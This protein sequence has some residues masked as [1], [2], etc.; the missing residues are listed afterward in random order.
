MSMSFTTLTFLVTSRGTSQDECDYIKS[1][2]SLYANIIFIFIIKQLNS[3]SDEKVKV[4][5]ETERFSPIYV[6]YNRQYLGLNRHC[7]TYH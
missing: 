5:G 4:A 7:Y 3:F 2:I 6:T 1:Y